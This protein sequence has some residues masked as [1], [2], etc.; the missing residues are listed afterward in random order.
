MNSTLRN[1]MHLTRPLGLAFY[2]I[3]FWFLWA[4][5]PPGSHSNST[6]TST[7]TSSLLRKGMYAHPPS[8]CL[9]LPTATQMQDPWLNNTVRSLTAR[10]SSN[11]FFWNPDPSGVLN[12]RSVPKSECRV[13]LGPHWRQWG[14]KAWLDFMTWKSPSSRERSCYVYF[15]TSPR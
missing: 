14:C 15:R 11:F 3:C 13:G 2:S 4:K 6:S 9:F 5:V 7:T 12:P 1:Q 8:L 10:V